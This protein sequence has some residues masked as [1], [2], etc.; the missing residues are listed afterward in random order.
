[1]KTLVRSTFPLISRL[2][3]RRCPSTIIRS[4][5][6]VVI[7][8]VNGFAVRTWP[9]ICEKVLERIAPAVANCYSACTILSIAFVTFI[10]A[11]SFHSYP[12]AIFSSE[13]TD[14]GVTVCGF[15]PM[16]ELPMVAPT[17]GSLPGAQLS[18]AYP[19]NGATLALAFPISL[20]VTSAWQMCQYAPSSESFTS[21][22]NKSF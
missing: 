15:Y 1:M 9:H 8:A 2:F 18:T 3:F 19:L 12:T 5:R 21:Q 6:S 20:S 4:I 16:D 22:I 11:P 10:V 17:R 13:F 14:V 7:D